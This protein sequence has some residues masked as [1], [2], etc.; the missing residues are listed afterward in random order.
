MARAGYRLTLPGTGL[1]AEQRQRLTKR[2]SRLGRLLLLGTRH[3]RREPICIELI[4]CDA[5]RVTV[6]ARFDPAVPEGAAKPRDIHLHRLRGC[7]GRTL[8]P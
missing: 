3:E 8:A 7:V 5:K 1:T 6:S 4:L 2:C